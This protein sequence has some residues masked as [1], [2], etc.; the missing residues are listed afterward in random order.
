M[1]IARAQSLATLALAALGLMSCVW[2]PEAQVRVPPTRMA[3]Y[4]LQVEEGFGRLDQL[5]KIAARLPH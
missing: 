1:T 2:Q 5:P 4:E 3:A